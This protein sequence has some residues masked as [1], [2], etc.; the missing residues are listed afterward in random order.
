MYTS[1]MYL[2]TSVSLPGIGVHA[3]SPLASAGRAVLINLLWL[4]AKGPSP[5][6]CACFR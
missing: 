4:M 6:R 5:N 2:T 3:T 1:F